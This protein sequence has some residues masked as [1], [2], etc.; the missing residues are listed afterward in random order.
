MNDD[1]IRE[2]GERARDTGARR[3]AGGE[4]GHEEAG[5]PLPPS[6]PTPAPV[7]PGKIGPG[8][9]EPG[10]VEPGDEGPPSPSEAGRKTVPDTP[11][12][13]PGDTLPQGAGRE[14][15]PWSPWAALVLT[16]GLLVFYFLVQG[17][18]AVGMAAA[19]SAESG[20]A[21]VDLLT[22][23]NGLI[24]A[25]SVLVSAPLATALTVL[26]VSARG[27]VTA[28]L[29]LRLAGWRTTLG[30]LAVF[31]AFLVLWDLVGRALGRPPVPDFMIDAYTTAGP[32]PL[33]YL[34]LGL[35]VPVVEE[36]LFRG[37]LV[38]SLAASR[39]GFAGTVAVSAAAFA[40]VHFQYDLYDMSGVFLLGALFAVQRLRTGSLYL[41]ILLHAAVNVTATVQVAW[42]VGSGG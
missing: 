5:R 23:T 7:D 22:S 6:H 34:A 40:V 8:K 36:V 16:G 4:D 41:S 38:P 37:L 24:L 42:L 18:V 11:E 30:W 3:E 1:E 10:K 12:A 13:A 31:A 29:G 9:I 27:R 33:L 17:L 14:Y 21:M 39:L 28:Y 19:W 35:F 32:L 2:G 15:L 25:V 20:E 26:L